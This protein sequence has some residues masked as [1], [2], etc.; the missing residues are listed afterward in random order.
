MDRGVPELVRTYYVHRGKRLRDLDFQRGR[1]V[2][3]SADEWKERWASVNGPRHRRVLSVLVSIF[4]LVLIVILGLYLTGNLE[5]DALTSAALFMFWLTVVLW[6]PILTVR[7]YE[8]HGPAPGLYQL[9]VQA[10]MDTFVPYWEIES[11]RRVGL[12]RDNREYVAMAPRYPVGLV[13]RQSLEPWTLA[14]D[15][16]GEDGVVEL[17]RRVSIALGPDQSNVRVDERNP[18]RL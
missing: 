3:R 5:G 9:G 8:V 4:L 18:Q 10:N 6:V 1:P 17:E 11:T 13:F 2:V 7:H 14:V 15:F 16:L 12:G